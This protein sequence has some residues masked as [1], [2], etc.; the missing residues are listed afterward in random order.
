MGRVVLLHLHV[1]V[2]LSHR[3]EVI[4][5]HLI[6]ARKIGPAHFGGDLHQPFGATGIE[7]IIKKATLLILIRLGR[8]DRVAVVHASQGHGVVLAER[9]AADEALGFGGMPARSSTGQQALGASRLHRGAAIG[10]T[11]PV[12]IAVIPDR[13]IDGG[14]PAAQ[15]GGFLLFES[16]ALSGLRAASGPPLQPRSAEGMHKEIEQAGEAHTNDGIPSAALAVTLH[17]KAV[18]QQA[19]HREARGAESIAL[20][21]Q[22]IGV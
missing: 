18:I 2:E 16:Q 5:L 17:L 21:F 13:L 10:A 14:L 12:A 8:H 9:D 15:I 20:T 1:E 22:V 3:R 19:G 6:S 7:W 4:D 11:Q